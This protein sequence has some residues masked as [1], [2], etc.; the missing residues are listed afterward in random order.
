MPQN[1]DLVPMRGL[2]GIKFC[3]GGG[4][5]Q[6]SSGCLNIEPAEFLYRK[7]SARS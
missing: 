6:Q 2:Q 1:A 4:A 7:P 5:A 3:G